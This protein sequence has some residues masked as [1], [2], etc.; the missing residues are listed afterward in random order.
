MTQ[1]TTKTDSKQAALDILH[2]GVSDLMTSDGWKRS[3]DFRRKFRAYSFFNVTLILAQRPDATLVAGFRR[4]NEVDRFVK[5]GEKGIAILAPLLRQDP[6]HPENR[7]LVGF[8]R[9]FVFDYTQTEGEPIRLPEA[10]RLLQDTQEDRVRISGIKF[11]LAMFCASR[12][13]SVSWDFQHDTALGVYRPA[14]KQ[15]A[16]RGDISDN[17]QTKTLIHEATHML[18]HTGAD[19]RAMAELE[20]E[21]TAYLVCR[22]LGIETK[23]Y[24]F[25]YLAG[26]APDF[27]AL[28]QAGER[29]SKAADTILNTLTSNPDQQA[30]DH[31]AAA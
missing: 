25:P 19:D 23:D 4:W 3:L 6:E 10:P 14:Q 1:N 17:Q 12:G 15:I 2:K 28:I 21:T 26:W 22:A 9:V 5:K 31:Q 24:S 29:A 11:R 8:K 18:L 30:A 13:V 20:S 27:E 16:V 7:V